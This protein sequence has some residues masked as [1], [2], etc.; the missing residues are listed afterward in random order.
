M[1]VFF[2]N[3]PEI[4]RIF[5]GKFGLQT[6]CRKS[7]EICPQERDSI[8]RWLA[9]GSAEGYS[10]PYR[11]QT[12]TGRALLRE[13][14]KKAPDTRKRIQAETAKKNKACKS[15]GFVFEL[16][17]FEELLAPYIEKPQG[18]PT[19]VPETDK[20]LLN[21]KEPAYLP[22]TRS[23]PAKPTAK[24]QPQNFRLFQLSVHT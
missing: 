21:T 16:S 18:K 19:L 1:Q 11:S 3:N 2:R 9:S 15:A 4:Y 22:T 10:T 7:G 23:T 14:S 13:Q 20:A 6:A 24:G 8:R 12:N 5:Q 17:R